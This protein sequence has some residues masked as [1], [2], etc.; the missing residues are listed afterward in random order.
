M[1]AQAQTKNIKCKYFNTGFCKF[2]SECKFQHTETVCLQNN[3]KDK[4]CP[5]RH[6]EP[7]RFGEFCRRRTS[8][9]YKHQE[10]KYEQILEDC[11][12]LKSE[13]NQLISN[14]EETKTKLEDKSLELEKLKVKVRSTYLR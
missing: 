8:C 9:Y 4:K 13:I 10:N 3:C 1:A 12:L 14:L 11:K 7:C 5:H 6:P 2:K